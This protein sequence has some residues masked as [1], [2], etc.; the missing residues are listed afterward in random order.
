MIMGRDMLHLIDMAHKSNILDIPILDTHPVI[1]VPL[2]SIRGTDIKNYTRAEVGEL[3]DY[4]IKKILPES[5][6]RRVTT[7]A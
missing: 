7:W 4:Y 5:I 2:A 3:C 1:T 6:G